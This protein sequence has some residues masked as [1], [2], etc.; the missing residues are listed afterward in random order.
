[1]MLAGGLATV[2]GILLLVLG[3]QS[4]LQKTENLTAR[5]DLS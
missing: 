2:I 1:M 5:E 3:K 4:Q